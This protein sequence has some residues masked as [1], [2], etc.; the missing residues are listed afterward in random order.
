M[1]RL[2][3]GPLPAA[4][5]T[6]AVGLVML[7][8]AVG[9]QATVPAG[10]ARTS[11]S[12]PKLIWGPVTL[13]NGRSAFPTYHRLGVDVFQI[14]LNWAQTAP[15]PPA[16]PDNP[17]DPAYQWPAQLS[18]AIAQAARYRIKI[19]LLVQ[20]TPGWANGGRASDWAPNRASDYGNFL[21]AAARRYPSVHLWMIWGEPNRAGNFYPMPPNSKVG[22]RRYALILNAGYYALKGVSKANIVIGGD[23]W[24]FGTVEPADFVKWMRLPNGEPPPLD[25]YGHNPFSRRF[26]NLSEKPYY[27]GGRDINDIDTLDAQLDQVYHR[28]VKLWLSE[29]TVSSN[30]GNR[31]FSFAVSRQAQARWLTAAFRLANSVNYVAGMGWFDLVDQPPLPDNQA[32]TTGLLTYQLTPKPAYYAYQRA[33]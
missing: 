17:S 29:F 21:T 2:V 28:P 16:D 6:V 12:V 10:A 18:Q 30:H 22:P 3:P 4:L 8:L 27:P 31:A 33:P 1:R 14:D 13:P 32:L 20:G 23:T 19:C 15:T 26:P 9:A 11:G 24:S 25:Y 5:A 7:W